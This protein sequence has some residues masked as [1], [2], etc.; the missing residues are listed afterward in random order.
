MSM[1]TSRSTA[2]KFPLSTGEI[3]V[4]NLNHV[5]SK[6]CSQ[7]VVRPILIVAPESELIRRGTGEEEEPLKKKNWEEEEE[8]REKEE[9]IFFPF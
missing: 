2:A 8:R 7:G 1:S 6:P 9:D 5:L 3:L 4:A